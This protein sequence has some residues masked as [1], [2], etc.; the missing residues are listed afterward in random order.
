M[1]TILVTGCAG[2]I[3]SNLIDRLL[4]CDS[5]VHIIGIDNFDPFYD[6]SIK[7]KNMEGFV[8]NSRFSFYELDLSTSDTLNSIESTADVVVHLAAKAG[9]RPSII[10]PSSYIL[11]NIVATENILKWM[12][13][14]GMNNLVFASSSSVYG[15][16]KTIPFLETDNVDFPISPYAFTKKSCELLTYTYHS[17][18]Q[19]NVLNLRFFTVYGPRQRPDLAIHKFIN[20]IIKNESI[21]IYGDGSTSRDYTYISDTIQGIVSSIEYIQKNQNVY[22]II[23]LGNNTPI[24]LKDLIA[25]IEK[26][27]QIKANTIVLPMQEGDVNMTYAGINKAKKLLQ[28]YPSTSIEDGIAKFITWK[29]SQ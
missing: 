6:R 15:N 11:H 4:A 26:R 1:K 9:V 24:Q 22:E 5:D 8:H 29:L 13:R 7:L 2:F 21:E 23:N 20:Q 16:N 17:L 14:K 18:Y 19:M 3:G 27:L 28:Y 10:D 12:R 25:I